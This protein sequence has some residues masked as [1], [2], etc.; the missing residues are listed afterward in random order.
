MPMKKASANKLPCGL[1][2][3]CNACDAI[4]PVHPVTGNCKT[5]HESA[6]PPAA[7]TPGPWDVYAGKMKNG[8][9]IINDSEG[10]PVAYA[11]D[12]NQYAKDEQVDANARLIA[13]A[14]EVLSALKALVDRNPAPCGYFITKR[15]DDA[16]TCGRDSRIC[17]TCAKVF[18]ARAAI[19][20]AEGR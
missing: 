10:T 1:T 18:D 20:K 6:N 19:A 17:D 12:Y 5:C 15:S 16:Y 4:G 13:A 11:A 8:D 7:H 2:S 9:R 14:P 3:T